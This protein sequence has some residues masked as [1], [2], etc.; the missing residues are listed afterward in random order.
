MYAIIET[1]GK[2]VRASEGAVIMVEKLPA[3]VGQTVTFDQILLVSKEDGSTLIGTPVVAGAKAIGKVLDQGKGPK[4]RI[5]K[6]K[7]KTNY[8]RRAGHRQP[9]TKVQIEKIEL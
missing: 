9:F 3:E 4:I 6:Y 7:N 1:G 8:R 2:Q 5:F